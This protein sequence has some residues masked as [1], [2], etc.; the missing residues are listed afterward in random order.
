M[1]PDTHLQS[2]TVVFQ[3]KRAPFHEESRQ[4]PGPFRLTVR[5]LG[6]GFGVWGLGVWGFGVLVSGFGVWGFGVI[7]GRFEPRIGTS[8]IC[9]CK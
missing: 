9:M 2:V 1:Q 7:G 3:R 4:V 8:H 5:V 6:L